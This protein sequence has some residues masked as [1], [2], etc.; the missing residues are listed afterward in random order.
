[1]KVLLAI[2][3]G[4]AEQGVGILPDDLTNGMKT[5]LEETVK[6]GETMVEEGMKVFE[7]G[8][9]TGKEII[10]GVKDLLKPKE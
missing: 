1:V 3:T 7:E 9:D 2:A 8:A 10:E 4:I 5:T 6:L